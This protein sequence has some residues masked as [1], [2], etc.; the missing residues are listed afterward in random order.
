MMVLMNER[1]DFTGARDSIMS[2]VERNS[3]LFVYRY[4][5]FEYGVNVGV[6]RA[7]EGRTCHVVLLI[8]AF[9][10]FPHYHYGDI[11]SRYNVPLGQSF[12]VSL[13]FVYKQ[14]LVV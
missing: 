4:V 2:P 3:H 1:S 14:F 5:N 12:E 9:T 10:Y 13:T 8:K 6:E 7:L 11:V